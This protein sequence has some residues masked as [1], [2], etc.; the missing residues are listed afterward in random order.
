MVERNPV[1]SRELTVYGKFYFEN[2]GTTVKQI[3]KILHFL[4]QHFIQVIKVVA[5]LKFL[6]C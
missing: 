1:V 6:Q 2:I 5:I 3:K 4:L